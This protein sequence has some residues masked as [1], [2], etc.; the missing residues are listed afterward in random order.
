[1]KKNT[2]YFSIIF[3]VIVCLFTTLACSKN[4]E[5]NNKVNNI[6]NN[7]TN[8]ITNK[9]VN[10][11][12]FT[13]ED[14]QSALQTSIDKVEPAC[15]GMT[16]KAITST[17]NYGPSEDIISYFSGVIYKRE[18]IIEN[19]KLVNYKYYVATNRHGVI[20]DQYKKTKIYV[21]IQSEDIE[22]EATLVGYDSKV[23]IACVTFNHYTYIQ[24]VEFADSDAVDKGQFA[25]AIGNP[26]G[27]DFYG[28]VTFGVISSPLRY[29]QDDT[30]DDGVVDF[31][32][33]YIQHDVAIN[34][35]N[36]GGGL[37]T[38]DGKLLGINTIK[39]VNNNVENMSFSIPSNLVK[40]LMENYFEKNIPISRASIGI[41]GIEVREL[42]P[43]IM[44]Y[45]ELK[46]IP[47]IYDA[48][49]RPYGLYVTGLVPNGTVYNSGIKNDD[50]ILTIDG[51]K[52][53][54][55]IQLSSI[56]SDLTLYTVGNEVTLTYY[57]R[58]TG[59]IETVKVILKP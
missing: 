47:D 29:L 42:T 44:D 43:A 48:G 16:L 19:G 39:F 46:N 22:I 32:A 36:S 27:F 5:V 34:P 40:T 8:E 15:I 12:E 7:V 30:D 21:Y 41:K 33:S 6:T 56:L 13:I 38:L 26:G 59:T 35:G 23:D 18:E 55:S 9:V 45:Y 24:P 28:S 3:F 53:K 58:S 25:F 1:M 54:Q 57:K 20:S 51:I 37:F 14:L 11:E 31:N 4:S 10:Y 2:L 52:I 50:I 17:D 49:E